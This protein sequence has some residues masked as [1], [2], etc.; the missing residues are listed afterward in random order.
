MKG[1]IAIKM[2][3]STLKIVSLVYFMVL[4]INFNKISLDNILYTHN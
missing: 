1:E 4:K 3:F 2:K